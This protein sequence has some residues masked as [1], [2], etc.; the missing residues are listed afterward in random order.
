MGK[1]RAQVMSKDAFSTVFV[2]AEMVMRKN[3]SDK[4]QDLID[5]ETNDD[6]KSGL[7]QAQTIIYGVKE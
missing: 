4:I 3:L 2:Q 1:K 5:K 7:Q 6:V